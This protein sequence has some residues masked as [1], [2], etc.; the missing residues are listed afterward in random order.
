MY[1]S[2]AREAKSKIVY[3]GLTT[4]IH[5]KIEIVSLLDQGLFFERLIL[6]SPDLTYR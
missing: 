1:H 4:A 6:E 2:K 3:F 5:E